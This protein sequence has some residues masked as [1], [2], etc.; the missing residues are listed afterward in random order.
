MSG[1]GTAPGAEQDRPMP[2][3]RPVQRP[4]V[5]WLTGEVR[6]SWQSEGWLEAQYADELMRPRRTARRQ[7]LDVVLEDLAEVG[8]GLGRAIA[9]GAAGCARAVSRLRPPG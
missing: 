6:S 1:L 7:H 3:L 9:A 8:A 4:G 2:L 5:D